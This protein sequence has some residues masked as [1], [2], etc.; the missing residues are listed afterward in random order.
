MMKQ[1]AL[2]V[3]CLFIMGT[4][5]IGVCGQERQV[6]LKDKRVSIQMDKKP[7]F[8][9]FM[10]LIYVYDIAIGFEQS[11][12]DSEHDDYHFET[13]IPYDEPITLAPNG[14][15]RVTT[16]ARPIIDKHLIT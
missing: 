9:V 4:A 14:S 6:S 12:L 15:R 3:G 13:N 5:L 10:R 11:I 8:D 1:L 7:L 2:H 16:G